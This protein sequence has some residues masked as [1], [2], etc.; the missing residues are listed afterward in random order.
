MSALSYSLAW[1]SAR[2]G[3]ARKR[4]PPAPCWAD[5]RLL[6]FQDHLF[7]TRK[8]LVL[9]DRLLGVR[10]NTCAE[11]SPA[12]R[13]PVRIRNFDEDTTRSLIRSYRIHI[14]GD[15]GPIGHSKFTINQNAHRRILHPARP[16]SYIPFW[17]S[18]YSS[19]Y[20]PIY[21]R[22]HPAGRHQGKQPLLGGISMPLRGENGPHPVT[23]T[24]PIKSTGGL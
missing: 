15:P 18:C 9:H 11:A 8:V 4:P 10:G 3:P 19:L 21:D 22:Q 14:H 20:R 5:S 24:Q 17:S 1:N 12:H 2:R 7:R 16:K 6:V 23:G 13:K